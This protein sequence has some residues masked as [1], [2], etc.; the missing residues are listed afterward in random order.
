MVDY[1][2]IAAKALDRQVRGG[3]YGTTRLAKQMERTPRMIDAWCA[4]STPIRAEDLLLAAS[5]MVAGGDPERARAMLDEYVRGVTGATLGVHATP[6][7]TVVPGD[8]RDAAA[9]LTEASA[10]LQHKARTFTADG[11]LDAAESAELRNGTLAVH[12]KAATLTAIVAAA[13]TAEGALRF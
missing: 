1:G 11:V 2:R 12:C 10:A 7:G 8:A 13:G 9:D 4:G 5:C 3:G 6:A